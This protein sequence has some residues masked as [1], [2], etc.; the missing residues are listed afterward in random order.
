MNKNRIMQI[1]LCIT[2]V[3]ILIAAILVCYSLDA[4]DETEAISFCLEN[5]ETDVLH[6]ENLC[7]IPGEECSYQV[8]LTGENPKAY[9]VTLHFEELFDLGLRKFAFVKVSLDGKIILD[10]LIDTVM[11]SDDIGFTVDFGAEKDS[12]LEIT[13]Y[14]PLEVGNEAKGKEAIFD[15]Y[16]TASNER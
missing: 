7:L 12:Q 5:K 15:L 4:A 14:L 16:I 3:F 13:Y 1:T 10:D 8:T 11:R 2:S 9:D 6:F